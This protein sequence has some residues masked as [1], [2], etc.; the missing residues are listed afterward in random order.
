MRGL[1]VSC[2]ISSC[3]KALTSCNGLLSKMET[4]G[5]DGVGNWCCHLEWAHRSPC[6][7]VGCCMALAFH[8]TTHFR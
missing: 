3:R 4:K 5:P 6:G 7:A 8:R 2:D 1:K